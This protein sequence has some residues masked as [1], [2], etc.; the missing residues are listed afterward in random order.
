MTPQ[1]TQEQF[2]LVTPFTIKHAHMKGGREIVARNSLGWTAQI[3]LSD[4]D[5]DVAQARALRDWL[6]AVLPDEHGEKP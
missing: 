6:N 3:E 5:L 1:A 2:K 4:C